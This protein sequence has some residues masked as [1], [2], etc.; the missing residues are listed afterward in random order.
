MRQSK[1]MMVAAVA[2]GLGMAVPAV[3]QQASQTADKGPSGE[4]YVRKI[5]GPEVQ[6]KKGQ[7][8]QVVA[9][10]PGQVSAGGFGRAAQP[11]GFEVTIVERPTAQQGQGGGGA[12]GGMGSGQDRE[13]VFADASAMAGVVR[14]DFKSGPYADQPHKL[15][16]TARQTGGTPQPGGQAGPADQSLQLQQVGS[17][18][19]VYV[20]KVMPPPMTD[21]QKQQQQKEMDARQKQAEQQHQATTRAATQPGGQPAPAMEQVEAKQEM[22]PAIITVYLAPP[23]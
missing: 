19:D 11:Q 20:F 22:T 2:A 16:L 21:E 12:M 10:F 6:V 13:I 9:F 4:A 17:G 5:D 23:A 14:Y 7:T 1:W 18:Q 3:A 8:P 15:V